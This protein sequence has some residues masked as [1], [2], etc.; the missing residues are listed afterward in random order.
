MFYN[1]NGKDF[2]KNIKS[3]GKTIR[4][5]V[6]KKKKIEVKQIKFRTFCTEVQV[7]NYYIKGQNSLTK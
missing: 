7:I 1:K 2:T 4:A 5:L 6:L 3:V